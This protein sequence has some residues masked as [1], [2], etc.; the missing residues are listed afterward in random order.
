M[1]SSRIGLFGT[2]VSMSLKS[3][4]VG[5]QSFEQLREDNCVYVDK[6]QLIHR[7]VTSGRVYFLARPRRFGKSLLLSTLLHLFT[8]RR[9]L[10]KGLWIERETDWDWSRK[11]PVI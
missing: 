10:F 5:I 8:G 6:T 4:P 11:H 3:L 9:D 2:A 1:R 7:L